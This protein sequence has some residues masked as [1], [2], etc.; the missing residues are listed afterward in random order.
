[1]SNN[2]A[3]LNLLIS[4]EGDFLKGFGFNETKILNEF[5]IWRE[6]NS[7]N[8]TE[9]FFSELLK[10]ASLYNM[11]NANTQIEYYTSQ[12]IINTKFL[13][14]GDYFGECDKN[15][16]LEQIHLNK[17]IISNLT[18]SYKF[19]VQICANNCCSYCDKKNKKILTFEKAIQKKYLP[20]KKCTNKNCTCS[21]ATIPLL[22]ENGDLVPN[23]NC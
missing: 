3:V 1:M 14:N 4:K 15:Y 2:R 5:I 8:S 22:N 18:L 20:F 13:E 7:E 9:K 12:L 11:K 23:D 17:L 16:W 10:I 19:D 21:Y 6:N